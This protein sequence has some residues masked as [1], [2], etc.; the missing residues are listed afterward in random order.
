MCSSYHSLTLFPYQFPVTSQ[1]FVQC[2]VCRNT[3]TPTFPLTPPKALNIRG[4]LTRRIVSM[5]PIARKTD[6]PRLG[7]T[8]VFCCYK[9]YICIFLSF[10]LLLYLLGLL[11]DS[12][13]NKTK[14]EMPKRVFL[15]TREKPLGS[16]K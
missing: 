8:S 5:L 13:K 11:L 10:L 12:K 15:A 14:H 16:R 1:C 7:S 6:C 4:A 3:A 2:P 9:I